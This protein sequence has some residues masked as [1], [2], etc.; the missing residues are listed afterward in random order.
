MGRKR[1]KLERISSVRDARLFIIATEGEETEKKYFEDLV[2]KDWYPN[3]RVI[4]KVLERSNSASNPTII[5][6]LLEEYQKKFR[7]KFTVLG[8]SFSPKNICLKRYFV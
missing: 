8:K 3:P 5:L 4:V 6:N 7:L 2:S 1:K